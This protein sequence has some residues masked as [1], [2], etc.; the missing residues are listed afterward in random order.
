MCKGYLKFVVFVKSMCSLILLLYVESVCL[1]YPADRLARIVWF[2]FQALDR[3]W[4][5]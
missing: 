1:A 3:D 2:I 5:V 4:A